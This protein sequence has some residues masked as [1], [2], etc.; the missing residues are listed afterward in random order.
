MHSS[1][2]STTK[3]WSVGQRPR[4]HRRRPRP[5][6][7]LSPKCMVFLRLWK[8]TPLPKCILAMTWKTPSALLPPLLHTDGR[9]QAVGS[10]QQ[11]SSRAAAAR[12]AA[13]AERE[14]EAERQMQRQTGTGRSRG[15]NCLTRCMYIAHTYCRCIWKL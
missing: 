12:A 10:R 14:E 7:P 9:K 6:C 15:R 2:T 1:C 13:A 8:L 3:R 11:Q 5:F 4:G